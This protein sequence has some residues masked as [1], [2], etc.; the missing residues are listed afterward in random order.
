MGNVTEV[1]D[2]AFKSEVLDSKIPVLVDFWAP[3]CGPCK[4]FAPVF[5]TI[6]SKNSDLKFVKV[7][8]DDEEEEDFDDDE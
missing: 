4:R 1:T 3:W 2:S 8:T 5:E 6:A 7:N